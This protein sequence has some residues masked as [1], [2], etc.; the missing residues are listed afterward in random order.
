L[1]IQQATACDIEEMAALWQRIAPTRQMMQAFDA[2]SLAEWIE[3]APG[4]DISNY[5]LARRAN[6]RIAGF[7]GVWDQQSLKQLRVTAYSP[8]LAGVRLAYNSIAPALGARRLPRPGQPLS[9]ACAAHICVPAGEPGVLRALIDS[10]CTDL[11]GR[12]SFFTLGLDVHD[13]LGA[14]LDG[15]FAQ[16]TDVH[17]YITR[18][19]G[20][21][22]GPPLD[23]RPLHY[24]IALV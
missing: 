9:C 20:A 1:P 23:D 8:R 2:E 11:R 12:Y 16:P 21:W 6:G 15:L 7:I 13:P 24:E 22:S 5:Y 10:V 3:S 14:A 4:L 18:P 19:R 17:A